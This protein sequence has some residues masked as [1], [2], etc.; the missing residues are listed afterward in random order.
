MPVVTRSPTQRVSVLQAWAS[1]SGLRAWASSTSSGVLKG[2][3]MRR[4]LR[5]ALTPQKLAMVT[6]R[7]GIGFGVARVE[8][9]VL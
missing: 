1:C 7:K 3:V 5:G 2:M 9:K 8:M 4:L 6:A